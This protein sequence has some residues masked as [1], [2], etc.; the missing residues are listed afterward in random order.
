MRMDSRSTVQVKAQDL[1]VPRSV[2]PSSLSVVYIGSRSVG[3]G[4]GHAEKL[5]LLVVDNHAAAGGL[6]DHPPEDVLHGLVM[7]LSLV[8]LSRDG[9]EVS[10]VLHVHFRHHHPVIHELKTPHGAG[11]PA[12]PR[13]FF[14][15]FRNYCDLD[16]IGVTD[17]PLQVL[18]P[19]TI[20]PSRVKTPVPDSEHWASLDQGG[21]PEP[22]AAL[23]SGRCRRG[24][25]GRAWD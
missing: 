2:Q 7:L 17:P 4:V 25:C 10:R 18:S 8:L 13:S 24:R 11:L 6:L 9:R 21:L 15:Q 23:P 22:G 3:I 14:V 16:F 5:R 20:S 12:E 19:P 1:Q